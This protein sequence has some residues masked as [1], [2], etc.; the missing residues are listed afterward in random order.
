VLTAKLIRQIRG[1]LTQTQ[2]AEQLGSSRASI[3]RYENDLRPT[4]PHAKMQEKIIAYGKQHGVPDLDA[5]KITKRP[6]PAALAAH[7]F[8]PGHRPTAPAGRK[9]EAVHPPEVVDPTSYDRSHPAKE[10]KPGKPAPGS[11]VPFCALQIADA[12]LATGNKLLALR[13]QASSGAIGQA[14]TGTMTVPSGG[15]EI[16]FPSLPAPQQ[17][18]AGSSPPQQSSTPE[19]Q[20]KGT[21]RPSGAGA[22]Y[23]NDGDGN[24]FNLGGSEVAKAAIATGRPLRVTDL[25]PDYDLPPVQDADLSLFTI[26]PNNWR[27]QPRP[28][29]NEFPAGCIT[30]DI[31]PAY[32]LGVLCCLPAI[33][34]PN[35]IRSQIYCSAQ[36]EPGHTMCRRHLG[37]EP[38]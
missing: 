17:Q 29:P 37:F 11:G 1:K 5:I 3:D 26:G 16:I 6:V 20:S 23:V 27:V 36:V 28:A 8:Q 13:R 12:V 24:T 21:S 4:M 38:R 22:V 19:Q 18:P 34:Y 9:P 25:R 35:G 2:F 30:G 32:L 14:K 31:F 10:P 7:K 33:I 15:A